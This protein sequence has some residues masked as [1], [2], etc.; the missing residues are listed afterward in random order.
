[1]GT[2]DSAT[3]SRPDAEPL[4]APT[5]EPYRHQVPARRGGRGW[6]IA[7]G[8]VLALV[9]GGV[10]GC[11]ALFAAFGGGDA[12]WETGDA[13]AV[14]RL[15]GTIASS[16]ST[17][18]GVVTPEYV[19]GQLD[20]AAADPSVRAVLLRMDSPGGTVAASEEIALA[21]EAF[22]ERMP[23]VVSIGDVGASG[24]Y[25]VASQC[26]EIWAL[27]TSSV[28]SIGVIMQI[29]NVERLLD[30]VGVDL[31][32]ITK[33]ELKDAGSPFR[34]ADASD[35]A[36]F[37]EEIDFAYERFV[38]IVAEGRDMDADEVRKLATGRTWM[39]ARAMDLGLVDGIGG[40]KEALAAAAKAGGI[41][42]EPRVVTYDEYRFEELLT[43]FI[44][45]AS[46]L[47]G[48]VTGALQDVPVPR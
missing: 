7:V 19:H 47:T 18:D 15:D 20:A 26:D 37:R 16:G 23:V 24:A 39:G 40:Y 2:E 21:V 36:Y 31:H 12:G 5:N 34:S 41:E 27:S 46:R 30:K 11:L 35:L 28:G 45:L 42:G 6:M 10:F 3:G 17:L 4:A 25:M 32:V 8:V 33:G 29:P 9:A 38:E 22:S 1:M 14:I 43:G 44:G 13:V 48:G